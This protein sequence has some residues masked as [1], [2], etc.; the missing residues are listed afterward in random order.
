MNIT[1]Q[2]N[3]MP[4]ATV[5]N[6]QTDNLRRENNLR[7]V[8]AQPKAINQST[9]EKG[10][11]SDK[12]KA[13]T[14]A[15]DNEQVD[16]ANIRKRTEKEESTITDS[17][18]Q[19]G[20]SSSDTSQN[21]DSKDPESI[22]VQAEERE[23]KELKERDQEVRAHERAHASVGGAT[24]GTP[25][26]TFEMGPDGKRYAVGGEVSVDISPVPGDPKATIAKMQKI[27]AAALAPI[28]PSIQD[29]KVAAQASKVILEAQSELLDLK[30]EEEAAQSSSANIGREKGVLEESRQ[31]ETDSKESDFDTLINQTLDA[32]GRISPERSPD[33][34]ARA[35]RIETFYSNINLAYERNTTPQFQL[36]A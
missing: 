30:L 2:N 4:L 21:N 7:E 6:P 15:Q 23:I 32:Q 28:N 13:K 22:E 12:D 1:P 36:T 3:F 27:H 33:V 35:Q 14:P 24:T 8:I 20:E 29:T 18:Q 9:A 34:V 31:K 26:Y 5:V 10:V 11:A 17:P 16:L 19:E 25:T